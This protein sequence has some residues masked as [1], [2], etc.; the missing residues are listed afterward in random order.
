MSVETVLRESKRLI[1]GPTPKDRRPRTA[2]HTPR[3]APRIRDG[4]MT[5]RKKNHRQRYCSF[6]LCAPDQVAEMRV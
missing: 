4:V 3:P 1:G 2:A 6:T 5:A